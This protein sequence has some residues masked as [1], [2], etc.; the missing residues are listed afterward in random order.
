MKT[1][2]KPITKT[3]GTIKLEDGQLVFVPDEN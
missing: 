2:N 1:Y 3:Q